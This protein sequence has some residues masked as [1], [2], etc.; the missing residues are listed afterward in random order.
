MPR[1][2]RSN[3]SATNRA[4]A[5]RLIADGRMTDAGRATLPAD[6]DDPTG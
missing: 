6:L 4:M 3:W 5:R 2:P 1:R